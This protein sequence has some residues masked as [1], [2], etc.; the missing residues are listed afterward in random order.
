MTLLPGLLHCFVNSVKLDQLAVVFPDFAFDM[1]VPKI[2]G[3]A[4]GAFRL[5]VQGDIEWPFK[6]D[7]IVALC[8]VVRVTPGFRVLFDSE[9][10][11]GA[12]RSQCL[13][14]FNLC[15]YRGEVTHMF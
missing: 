11:F 7:Y 8:F 15:F 14:V 13:D 6:A 5:S 3:D 4:E 12:R 9:T 2:S 1:V 10:H